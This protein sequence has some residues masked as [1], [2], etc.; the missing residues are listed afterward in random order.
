MSFEELTQALFNLSS[1]DKLRAL[2]LLN[3][4]LS[5]EDQ[6]QLLSQSIESIEVWSPMLEDAADMDILLTIEKHL[7]AGEIE[8]A[9]AM[10]I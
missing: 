8:E 7:L 10:M 2:W 3:Q 5:I 1:E 4:S 9:Q 6:A